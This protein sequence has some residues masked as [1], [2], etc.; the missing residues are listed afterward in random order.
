MTGVIIYH[1]LT[2][3]SL[4]KLRAISLRIRSP[5][6]PFARAWSSA[7]SFGFFSERS[8]FLLT[9]I[10]AANIQ[11]AALTSRRKLR[12]QTQAIFTRQVFQHVSQDVF[13]A[14]QRTVP[15]SLIHSVEC[16]LDLIF[17]LQDG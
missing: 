11:L 4:T 16:R 13:Q 12:S 5:L 7:L 15:M 6:T 17:Q 1:L 10:P 9:L 8:A 3:V 2:I 14:V